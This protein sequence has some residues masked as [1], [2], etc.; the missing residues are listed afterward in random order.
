MNMRLLSNANFAK[1]WLCVLRADSIEIHL[2]SLK[3]LAS[4]IIG[5]IEDI[6]VC[7]PKLYYGLRTPIL[8][9][10]YGS[11][12]T[13]LGCLVHHVHR[14]VIRSIKDQLLSR[15]SYYRHQPQHTH[16]DKIKYF[17]TKRYFRKIL[18]FF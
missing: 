9:P 13:C 6:I 15:T 8:Q 7:L 12:Q 5:Q 17:L 11:S 10:H 4:L 1:S 2:Y 14:P 16:H 3:T 18:F